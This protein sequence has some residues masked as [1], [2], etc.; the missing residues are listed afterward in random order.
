MTGRIIRLL[1]L[2]GVLIGVAATSDTWRP[3]FASTD[4]TS[5]PPSEPST[6]SSA[7]LPVI[8]AAAGERA[9][10]V[11]VQAIGTARAAS[12]VTLYPDVDGEIV[13]IPVR[14]GGRVEKG[15]VILRLDQRH[16][17]LAV[18]LAQTHVDDAESTAERV[19]KLRQSNVRSDANVRDAEIALERARLELQQARVALSDRTLRAP[20]DGV[21]GIAK[22]EVG[23]RITTET[24]VTTLDDRSTLL[25]EF[26]IAE[27]FFS[28]LTLG[29]TIQARTPSFPDRPIEGQIVKIDS[30]ID[31]IARTVLL[32]AA[33]PNP[34]DTLRPGMSLGVSLILPGPVFATV[35]ELSIQWRDGQSY[36][37]RIVDGIAERVDVIARRRLNQTVLV[38]GDIASGDTIV[39]E[40]VQRLRPGSP[41]AISERPQP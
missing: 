16:A 21:L 6:R 32:R 39:V 3:L 15:D 20:F 23:D 1:I 33:F 11:I 14:A 31:P 34:E 2:V 4:P 28:R 12:S 35:P 27:R 22:I 41:V 30:R 10:T 38:D 19:L 17:A 36:V 8:V 9:D 37:W 5:T 7:G 25:V 13:E 26:E 24:P 29:D 40:G 18:Q